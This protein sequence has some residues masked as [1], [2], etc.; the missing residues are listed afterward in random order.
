[1]EK[2]VVALYVLQFKRASKSRNLMENGVPKGFQNL[3]KLTTFG[4]SGQ[5]FEI[6]EAVFE[7]VIC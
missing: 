5:I 7:N 6:C 1:M 3:W 2:K 4:S